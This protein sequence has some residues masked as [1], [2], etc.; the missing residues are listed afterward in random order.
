[1]DLTKYRK[2]PQVLPYKAPYHPGPRDSPSLADS[3]GLFQ[4]RLEAVGADDGVYR[5]DEC[6]STGR[7]PPSGLSSTGNCDKE[8]CKENLRI[9]GR[10]FEAVRPDYR[11]SRRDKWISTGLPGT[12]LPGLCRRRAAP[13]TPPFFC[14]LIFDVEKLRV[15]GRFGG[16]L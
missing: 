12:Q 5:R 1:M 10:P 15:C 3:G 14:F 8:P 11:V 4:R 6:T 9:F 7:G 13:A 2:L 16:F